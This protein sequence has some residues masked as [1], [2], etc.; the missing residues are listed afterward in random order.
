MS[1][2]GASRDFTDSECNPPCEPRLMLGRSWWKSL[3]YNTPCDCAYY[4]ASRGCEYK[5]DV[6]KMKREAEEMIFGDTECSCPVCI[7]R[8]KGGKLYLAYFC[9]KEVKE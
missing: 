7:D 6:E 2:T 5:S 9:I 3:G 8:K 1:R 4:W